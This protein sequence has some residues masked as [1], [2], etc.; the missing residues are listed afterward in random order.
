MT[1]KYLDIKRTSSSLNQSS[2]NCLREFR[3][4]S[5]SFKD[6]WNLP[7]SSIKSVPPDYKWNL[8]EQTLCIFFLTSSAF[9]FYRTWHFIHSIPKAASTFLCKLNCVCYTV[10]VRKKMAN[11]FRVKPPIWHHPCT[12]NSDWVID[13]F[14]RN[15]SNSRFIGSKSVLLALFITVHTH[16]HY[17]LFSMILARTS[18]HMHSKGIQPYFFLPKLMLHGENLLVMGGDIT[19]PAHM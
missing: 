8:K 9:L 3:L 4:S 11:L 7:K 1:F 5:L 16:L 18:Y 17:S 10:V 2:S 13:F 19:L 6:V 12:F 15:L 14:T